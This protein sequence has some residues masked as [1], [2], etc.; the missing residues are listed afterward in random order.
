MNMDDLGIALFWET[1]ILTPNDIHS[2]LFEKV[3]WADVL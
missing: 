2:F 1:P 3:T